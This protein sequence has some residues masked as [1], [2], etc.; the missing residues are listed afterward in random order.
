MAGRIS[1]LGD[2]LPHREVSM[3]QQIAG[4]IERKAESS[5]F[6]TQNSEAK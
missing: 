6:P 1:A 5:F 4:R 3:L 2:Q